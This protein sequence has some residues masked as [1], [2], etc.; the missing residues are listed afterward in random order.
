MWVICLNEVFISAAPGSLLLGG[1][2]RRY[3]RKGCRTHQNPTLIA[4][5][6]LLVTA[7]VRW[8]VLLA[9]LQGPFSLLIGQYLLKRAHIIRR[10][11]T[12]FAC[13]AVM[14]TRSDSKHVWPLLIISWS[15][16][17]YQC[18]CRSFQCS[19]FFDCVCALHVELDLRVCERT[20][21]LNIISRV[22]SHSCWKLHFPALFTRKAQW[23]LFHLA[24][25]FNILFVLGLSGTFSKCIAESTQRHKP[26]KWKCPKSGCI[27]NT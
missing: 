20:R 24:T 25:I 19:T 22:G 7:A 1:F 8:R 6:P 9:A 4:C 14:E 16:S 11:C 5:S 2:A 3:T 18:L 13:V 27:N 26:V 12:E 10:P 17:N 21:K 15:L 23:P